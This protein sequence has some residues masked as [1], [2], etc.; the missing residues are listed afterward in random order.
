METRPPAERFWMARFAIQVTRGLL[1]DQRARRR[2]M[3][4][5]LFVALALVIGGVIG[6]QAWFAPGGTAPP[7][8]VFWFCRGWVTLTPLL[9]SLLEPLGNRRPARETPETSV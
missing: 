9:L 5:L 3:A 8:I 2:T 1:R 7:F 4:V 6:L